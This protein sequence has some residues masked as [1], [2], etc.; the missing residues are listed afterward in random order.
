MGGDTTPFP[1]RA[2]VARAKAFLGNVET[3]FPQGLKPDVMNA[4]YGT[5]EAVPLQSDRRTTLT[6]K[7]L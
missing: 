3:E 2:V 7:P 4:T 6:V 1:R 5:A